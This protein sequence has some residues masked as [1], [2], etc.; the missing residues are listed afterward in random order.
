MI[1]AK[2]VKQSHGIDQISRIIVTTLV[3]TSERKKALTV[4]VTFHGY[5]KMSKSSLRKPKTVKILTLFIAL[6]VFGGNAD[7]DERSYRVSD[8][9]DST[10]GKSA[11]QSD[12]FRST[13]KDAFDSPNAVILPEAT[14]YQARG[15]LK[16]AKQAEL[17]GR[18]ASAHKGLFFENDFTYLCDEAYSDWFL[19]DSLKRISMPLGGCLDIA[20]Q[21]RMRYH[22]ERNIRGL[23]LTGL[24]DDFLLHRTRLYADW[25]IS[26]NLRVYSEFLDAESNYEE[27]LPRPIEVNRHDMQNLFLD[28]QL[29]S[30]DDNSVTARIG[31]QEFLY[32]DQRVISPLD[33]ANTRRTFQGISLLT[34]MGDWSIDGFW[35]HPIFPNARD[36]DAPD[37]DQEFMG[38]Y[39]SYTGFANET[40]D[41]YLLRY[42][43]G[44]AINNFKF[45]TFGTRWQGSRDNS[46][47]DCELAYQWGENTDGSD[48]AAGMATLGLGRRIAN[49]CWNP[50][51]WAYYDYASG[52]NDTGAGNGFHH[53]FPLAHK[54]NGFMDLFGRRNLEDV[55]LKFSVEPADH[56]K[57]LVWYHYFFLATQSD[58]PYSVT[59]TPFNPGNAPGSTEL[60]HEIDLLATYT[61]GPRHSLSLGYSRFFSGNYYATT[62]GVPFSGDADFFYTEY[63][64]NF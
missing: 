57:L 50:E 33:W 18:V 1:V 64:I 45:N 20:G 16:R 43:N 30:Q 17:A 59:M 31:R 29:I 51:V 61:I 23:G 52:D 27:F 5:R 34:E 60:G 36:F 62:P 40:V 49:F 44:R 26:S 47:W 21:Y 46:L 54:Y 28:A 42:L 4:E 19:G 14:N 13:T 11:N 58:T 24:D 35:T 12:T 37:R 38:I 22:G 3:T 39:S 9:K 55:N 2:L 15:E 7:G 32:G 25:Q 6:L 63:T 41:V 10:V 56:L 53:N 48:H 8:Q